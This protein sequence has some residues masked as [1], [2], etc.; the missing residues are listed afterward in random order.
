MPG[1]RRLRCCASATMDAAARSL[2]LPPG[3]AHSALPRIWMWGR[4]A[5]MLSRRRRGVFPMRWRRGMPCL[6]VAS[7]RFAVAETVVHNE[8]WL[9]EVYPY[10]LFHLHDQD[11]TEDRIAF[12]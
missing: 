12:L 1:A 7:I 11:Q 10:R 5:V 3:L 2:T 4:W 6:V 8:G 9:G